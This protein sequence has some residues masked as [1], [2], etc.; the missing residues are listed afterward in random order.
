MA[1]GA[2]TAILGDL[3]HAAAMPFWKA[4]QPKRLRSSTRYAR[5]SAL[6]EFGKSPCGADC[7]LEAARFSAR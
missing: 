2:T 3:S 1:R 6:G 7:L 4:R 5:G